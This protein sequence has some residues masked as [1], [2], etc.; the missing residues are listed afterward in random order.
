MSCYLLLV[1]PLAIAASVGFWCLSSQAE[2]LVCESGLSVRPVEAPPISFFRRL[3]RPPGAVGTEP[4]VTAARVPNRENTGIG[5][6][7]AAGHAL[8]DGPLACGAVFPLGTGQRGRRS[9]GALKAGA[10]AAGLALE[11]GF[12]F[13]VWHPPLLVPWSAVGTIGAEKLLWVTTCSASIQIGNGNS[14]VFTFASNDLLAAA[15]PWVRLE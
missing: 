9:G 2:V 1:P 3:V 10:S 14:M 8:R 4:T 13:G 6:L 15:R 5:Q 7:A 12:S 11:T